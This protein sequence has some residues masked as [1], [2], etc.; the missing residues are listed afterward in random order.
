MKA[1]TVNILPMD[2]ND[3]TQNERTD[4]YLWEGKNDVDHY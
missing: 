4:N 3:I 1:N 2:V